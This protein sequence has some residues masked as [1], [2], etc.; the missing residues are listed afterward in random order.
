MLVFFFMTMYYRIQPSPLLFAYELHPALRKIDIGL[1]YNT[2]QQVKS[3]V[4]KSQLGIKNL[5]YQ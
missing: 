3:S 5:G 1:P 2:N 4:E